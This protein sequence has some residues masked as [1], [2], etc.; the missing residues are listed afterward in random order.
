MKSAKDT[1]ARMMRSL[2]KRRMGGS[3]VAKVALEE[4]TAL[5]KELGDKAPISVWQEIADAGYAEPEVRRAALATLAAMRPDARGPSYVRSFRP[6]GGGAL[7]A[8]AAEAVTRL[9]HAS[10]LVTVGRELFEAGRYAWARE[11]YYMATVL[12]PNRTSG[13]TGLA[14]ARRAL[15]A[16]DPKAKTA[17]DERRKANEAL[18]A[19]AISIPA[20]PMV[21]ACSQPAPATRRRRPRSARRCAT[22]D[23]LPKAE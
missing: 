13:F 18:L 9:T 17:E 22:R 7:E 16:L 23:Y 14:E 21:K 10:D 15:V 4:M 12:G 3:G 20:T 8:A 11:L 1:E 6:L 19:P 2:A 5:A